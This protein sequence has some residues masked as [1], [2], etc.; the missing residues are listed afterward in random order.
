MPLPVNC[1]GKLLV[2]EDSLC[3]FSMIWM[4]LLDVALEIDVAMMEQTT[5]AVV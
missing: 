1:V 3:S 2:D 4:V 5:N